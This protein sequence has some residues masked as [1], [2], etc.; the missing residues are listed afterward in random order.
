MHLMF[1]EWKFN[2]VAMKFMF[3]IDRY[4][5]A[6]SGNKPLFPRFVTFVRVHERVLFQTKIK[7]VVDDKIFEFRSLEL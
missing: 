3:E 1:P 7:L 4:S 6:M 5:I 2:T